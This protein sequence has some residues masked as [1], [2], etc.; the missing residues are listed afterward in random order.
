MVKRYFIYGT[1]GWLIEVL[2]TGLGS[3]IN[4]QLTL[5]SRTYL[6]MFPIYGLAVFLEFIHDEIREYKWWVR[7]LVYMCLIFLIE[8]LAGYF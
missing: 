7:G 1:L 3:L 2:W 8:Y 6:W 4:G 5:E